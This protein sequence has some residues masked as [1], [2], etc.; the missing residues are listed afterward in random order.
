MPHP[1]A[2]P[3]DPLPTQLITAKITP[4][5]SPL[6]NLPRNEPND[7]NRDQPEINLEIDQPE[8]NIERVIEIVGGG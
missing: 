3:L 8:I 7:L 1:L 5:K 4:K 6:P 2:V